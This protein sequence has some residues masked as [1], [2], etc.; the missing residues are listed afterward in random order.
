MVKSINYSLKIIKFFI[1][2][3]QTTK[4]LQKKQNFA[5][6]EYVHSK[7]ILAKIANN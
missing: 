2:I 4:K 5:K 6:Y 7:T 1:K 3:L